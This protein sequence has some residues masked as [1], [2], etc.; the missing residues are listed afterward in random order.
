[1]TITL[2]RPSGVA[3]TARTLLDGLF[4]DVVRLGGAAAGLGQVTERARELA[5]RFSPDDTPEESGWRLVYAALAKAI[6]DA[7]APLRHQT[8]I[9]DMPPIEHLMQIGGKA[10][11]FD[12]IELPD[13]FLQQPKSLPLLGQIAPVLQAALEEEGLRRWYRWTYA[14]RITREILAFLQGELRELSV[15]EIR[16][17]RDILIGLF[18]RNLRTGMAHLTIDGVKAAENA[19]HAQQRDAAAELALFT[20]LGA[21]SAVLVEKT[22]KLESDKRREIVAWS[23]AW[24]DGGSSERTSAW[25]LLRRLEAGTRAIRS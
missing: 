7:A 8:T 16:P 12:R 21:M 24:P 25:D 23:P 18:D 6:T 9:K 3:E 14:A 13:S 15:E 2:T 10:I 17:R 11:D 4:V 20:V 5:M 1:M 19:R 22:K